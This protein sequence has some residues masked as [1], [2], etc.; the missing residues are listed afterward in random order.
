[1]FLE[2]LNLNSK[3]PLSLKI[4]YKGKAIEFTL[5]S[6]INKRNKEEL[7]VERQYEL[8]NGYI[9]YKGDA[10]QKELFSLYEKSEEVIMST[11]MNKHLYPLPKEMVHDILDMFDMD[12]VY[13][14]IKN[15]YGLKAPSSL[16]DKFDEQIEKDGLGTRIQ[17]YDKNDYYQLA[18]FTLP[19]KAVLGPIAQ[20]GYVKQ[21]EIK[22]LHKEYMLYN[23]ISSHKLGQY[24][25]AQKLAGVAAKLI[26]LNIT[27]NDVSAVTVIEKQLP[28]EEM[29][30]Y[31]LAIIIIQK[32]A[33]A[34]I[35]TDD[36]VKNIITRM[37]N[38]VINKLKVK[39]DSSGRISEKRPKGESDGGEDSESSIE[40]FRVISELSRGQI[41]ELD[42]SVS[43][44]DILVNNIGV[45]IDPT[46]IHDALISTRKIQ[47]LPPKS[48]QMSL[49]G[50]IFKNIIDPRGL[51]YIT[52]ESVIN[53]MIVG[54]AYLWTLG[55]R[56]LA[57]LLLS[58]TDDTISNDSMSINTTVNRNRIPKEIKDELQIYFPHERVINATTTSS[59]VGEAINDLSNQF[60]TKR[61]VTIV[62]EKYTDQ[63]L[64]N[65]VVD[66]LPSDLKVKLAKFYIDHEKI[67][68][69]LN[70]S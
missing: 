3:Y 10:F 40:I 12:D 58:V 50:V 18:S 30:N 5:G 65:S 53:L 8:F 31:I 19:I 60:Y 45:P 62:P 39:G 38:Y 52:I 63:I 48:E 64:I 20:F 26:E 24:P 69:K 70:R 14:F 11:I 32:V 36:M 7:N 35:V 23:F 37:Y 2:L 16:V 33:V 27:D 55:H 47:E 6:L 41:E 28:R 21:S 56:E 49:I 15:V 59:I 4:N 68:S 66:V 13:N 57:V 61:W 43:D 46:L 67:I 51:E 1:M 44:I 42:W 9:K 34:D 17:T 25:A 22:G 54:F 29:A